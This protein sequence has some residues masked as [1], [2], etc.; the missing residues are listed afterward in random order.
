MVGLD[1]TTELSRMAKQWKTK[2]E[3]KMT[4]KEVSEEGEKPR[5]ELL[6]PTSIFVVDLCNPVKDKINQIE[7]CSPNIEIKPCNPIE[8]IKCLPDLSTCGPGAEV[9]NLQNQCYPILQCMPAFTPCF[10]YIE[11]QPCYP[12][13]PLSQ[14]HQFH[15]KVHVVPVAHIQV[16]VIL[17][18]G[19]LEVPINQGLKFR[20]TV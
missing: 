8:Q 18:L 3:E 5:L 1:D 17:L 12:I 9:S 19:G 15:L 16:L 7:I 20:L 11:N 10:P 4:R 14:M 6:N 13:R 2:E